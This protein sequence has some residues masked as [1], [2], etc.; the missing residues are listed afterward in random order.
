MEGIHFI[1]KFTDSADGKRRHALPGCYVSDHYAST[2]VAFLTATAAA[3]RVDSAAQVMLISA[4]QIFS[5]GCREVEQNPFASIGKLLAE[6]TRSNPFSTLGLC[7]H[8]FPCP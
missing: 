8:P 5:H 4:D 3:L 6:S 7:P 1:Q 2:R